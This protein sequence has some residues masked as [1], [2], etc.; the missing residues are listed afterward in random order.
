MGQGARMC[1]YICMSGRAIP[2]THIYTCVYM[3]A[4][5]DGNLDGNNAPE[6]HHGGDDDLEGALFLIVIKKEGA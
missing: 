1:S 6:G 4:C 5:L 3:H 2:Y